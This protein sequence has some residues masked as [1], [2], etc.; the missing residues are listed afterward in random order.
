MLTWTKDLQF[1]FRMLRRRPGFAAM[2][3]LTLALGIG[4]TTALFGVFRTVFLEALPLP[5]SGRLTFVMEQGGFGCCGPASGPDYTDWVARRRA[6]SGMGI[7]GP[8]SAT[9]TG[10]GEAERVYATAASASVFHLLGVA[11][12][13]GR[14]FT[15]DD[16]V[17]PSV[18][19]LGYGLWQRRFG[20]RRDILG[21]T[22]EI[23]DAPYTIIGVMPR[24]FDVPSPWR[25]TRHHQLYTPFNDAW[26]RGN[27]GS[28]SYPVLARLAPGATLQAAQS[29]MDRV[30]RELAQ[31]YPA[32]NSQRTARV[33]TAHDYM[34]G[35]SGRELGYILG[36]AALVLLIACG[37][38]A[39]LQL[40]RAA[41]RETELA[42]RA[43]LGEVHAWLV[44]QLED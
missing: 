12:L 5:D 23:D 2:V 6:F 18:V 35:R 3:L 16:Q 17:N 30:M 43:A 42:V 38:V 34:Y 13:F 1:A 44:E 20:G 10:D 8:T 27:R 41:A 7:I 24:G 36:A 39:G 33:F 21:K 15:T 19:I 25:G 11:P 22:L 28:H 4:C 14:T 40:A 26:L 9:L 31:E 37:N 29:D 32:T